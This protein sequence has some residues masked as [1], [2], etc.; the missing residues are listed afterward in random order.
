MNPAG[1]AFINLIVD[2]FYAIFVLMIFVVPIVLL[3]IFWKYWLE[4]VRAKFL[5]EQKYVLLELRLPQEI[6]KSPLAMEVF[7][8]SLHQTGGEGTW[9][10]RYWKGS[11]RAWFS[12]E[13]V[14]IGGEVKFFIWT[15]QGQRKN[16]ESQI[17]GQYPNVEIFEAIDYAKDWKYD[18][19]K[20]DVWG[21]MFEKTRPSFY[22]IKTYVDFGLDKDPKE[23]FKIDPITPAIEY[24]GSL[25]QGEYAAIQIMIRAHKA[26]KKDPKTGKMVDWKEEAKNEIKA[27]RGE[28]QNKLTKGEKGA[29]DSIENSISKFAFD[30]GIRAI[31]FADKNSYKTDN[32][33]GITG[34]FRQYNANNLNGFKPSGT[35]SFDYPWEDPFGNRLKK[36]KVRILNAYKARTFFPPVYKGKPFVMNTEELATVFHFPGR[37][38]TTP[39]FSRIVAKKSEAPSN[40]PI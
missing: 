26:E 7:I 27:K 19:E 2:T 12:L 28:D 30:C 20:N 24:L 5:L 14:S 31:Y 32:R 35:T 40:L 13:L 36:K 33:A 22:P 8:T 11:Q 10:D 17:Y 18:P 9:I 21:C 39:T 29:L 15:R 1:P 25:G 34:T 4:Y 38:S 3:L 6:T 37:V 23:E 16:I